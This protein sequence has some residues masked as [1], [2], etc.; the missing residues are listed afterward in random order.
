MREILFSCSVV[1]T[2]QGAEPR[3][4]PPPLLQPSRAGLRCS[5]MAAGGCSVEGKP[6]Y[7]GTKPASHPSLA[8]P[9]TLT[10]SH[11]LIPTSCTCSLA[12][13]S[14]G[15]MR[16]PMTLT[17]P[18]TTSA[19]SGWSVLMPTRPW[20]KTVSGN[21][22]RCHSTSLSLSNWPGLEAY[23][24]LGLDQSWWWGNF[25]ALRKGEI[26]G[27]PRPVLIPPYKKLTCPCDNTESLVGHKRLLGVM[28]FH[29]LQ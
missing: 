4:S 12:R 21:C 25:R 5:W 9:T 3:L 7:R 19:S 2:Y 24:K 8:S 23:G 17:L 26:P 11:G 1:S 13:R 22:A 6:W 16:D 27:T 14:E 29:A 18:C 15:C 28:H 10:L 20:W